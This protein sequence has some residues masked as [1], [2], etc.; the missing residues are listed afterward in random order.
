MAR[1][2]TVVGYHWWRDDGSVRKG[3]L[4]CTS[5]QWVTV[6]DGKSAY[7]RTS[8][9]D[10]LLHFMNVVVTTR[11]GDEKDARCKEGSSIS[12]ADTE[13]SQDDAAVWL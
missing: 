7:S 1:R 3:T 12:L 9:Q 11:R 10:F 13:P 6:D 5:L 2:G 8:I 4:G